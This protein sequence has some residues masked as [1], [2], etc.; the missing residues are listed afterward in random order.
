[1]YIFIQLQKWEVTIGTSTGTAGTINRDPTDVAQK[2]PPPTQNDDAATAITTIM[3][4]IMNTLAA[5]TNAITNVA[6]VHV[7][8]INATMNN[9]SNSKNSKKSVWLSVTTL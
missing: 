1:M 6:L 5:E 8:L 2:H 4:E 9:G 7:P 3:T